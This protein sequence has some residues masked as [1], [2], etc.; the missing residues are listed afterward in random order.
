MW[1]SLK[2]YS[3]IRKRV[4]VSFLVSPRI[5]VRFR[6]N[7]YI[8]NI[9]FRGSEIFL[10]DC[11]NNK[12]E[13]VQDNGMWGFWF[14]ALRSSNGPIETVA[15]WKSR[16]CSGVRSASVRVENRPHSH[17]ERDDLRWIK[18]NWRWRWIWCS[19]SRQMIM[20]M[21]NFYTVIAKPN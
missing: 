15:I 2:K 19:I 11:T 3:H 17:S 10:K 5:S 6:Q 12:S 20:I 16:F 1:N 8:K 9:S 7:V 14:D 18:M 21:S 4:S 13:H